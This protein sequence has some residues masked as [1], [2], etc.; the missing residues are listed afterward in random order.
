MCSSVIGNIDTIVD[1][2]RIIDLAF[3]VLTGI[4]GFIANVLS[5]A[6]IDHSP[7]ITLKGVDSG[8]QNEAKRSSIRR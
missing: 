4:P 1:K 2:R 3:A 8:P 6:E 5:A 7:E